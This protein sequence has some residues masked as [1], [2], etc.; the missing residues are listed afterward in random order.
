MVCVEDSRVKESL[1]VDKEPDGLSDI[2]KQSLILNTQH[3][4]EVRTHTH[5]TN[6]VALS[7]YVVSQLFFVGHVLSCPVSC[8]LVPLVT[9]GD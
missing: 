3:V 1:S 9:R 2:V 4:R 7:V 8:L 6:K 5:T